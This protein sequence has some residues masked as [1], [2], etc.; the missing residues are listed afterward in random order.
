MLA[1]VEQLIRA[2]FTEIT[3]PEERFYNEASLQ[4]ELA[5]YLRSRLPGGWR[6]YLEL[7]ASWFHQA[8]RG[9]TK[10][11]IDLAVTD[12]SRERAV[13]VELK[14]PR[15]GQHPEQMFKACQDLQFLEQLIAAGFA[16]GVFAMHV[17]DPLYYER[18]SR[19]GIYAHFRAGTAICGVI[20]KPTGARDRV[21]EIRGSYTPVWLPGGGSHR[22]WVQSVPPAA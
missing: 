7:P 18:G 21:A 13:A 1:C 6:V 10:K 5:L 16:G 2:F 9:L 19:R 17:R 11:E 3:D 14:C 12:G 22:Y 4:H 20:R 8:A 15:Q